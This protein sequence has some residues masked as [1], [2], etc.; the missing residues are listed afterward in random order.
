MK[1]IFR[2]R[3]FK[4]TIRVKNY[5]ELKMTEKLQP[6]KRDEGHRTHNVSGW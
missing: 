6:E 3:R 4:E 2:T 5:Y 1:E